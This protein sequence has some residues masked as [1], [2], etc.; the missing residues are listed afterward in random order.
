MIRCRVLIQEAPED[1]SARCESGI[2]PDRSEDFHEKR[3]ARSPLTA[4]CF[5]RAALKSRRLHT[6]GP[7]PGDP[8]TVGVSSP[9]TTGMARGSV[10]ISGR[11]P[12]PSE[13]AC[14]ALVEEARLVADHRVP[15]VRTSLRYSQLITFS[16]RSKGV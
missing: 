14:W 12:Q 6:G 1:R 10:T 9:G 5:A 8:S 11:T 4:P 16:T 2:V 15:P 13:D 7:A 3:R